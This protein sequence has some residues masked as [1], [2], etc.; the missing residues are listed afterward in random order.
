MNRTDA[1]VS[2]VIL[3]QNSVVYIEPVDDPFFAAH[4]D[5]NGIF[6]SRNA[7]YYF[8][9]TY[10]HILACAEQYQY[11]NPNSHDT[12]GQAHCTELSSSVAIQRQASTINLSPF[13]L[14]TA[15]L[16]DT[17][18]PLANIFGS[19]GGSGAA[20]LRASDIIFHQVSGPLPNNQWIIEVSAWF[21]T[22]LARIQHGVVEFATGPP[23]AFASD[24]VLVN[25]RTEIWGR[26][27]SSIK[28]GD[29]DDQQSFSALGV[30]LTLAIGGTVILV[31]WCL[32][33]FVE[34]LR[35]VLKK[36]MDRDE[37][38]KNDEIEL[39]QGGGGT[40][41]EVDETEAD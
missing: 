17:L 26:F 13:A 29:A 3:A 24:P 22:A 35:K 15:G 9:D 14:L 19:I 2:L 28:F 25:G 38:R 34:R 32:E 16:V 11:C 6:Q 18:L 31:S 39:L 41:L 10:F 7:T 37:Q 5:F 30:G 21:E 4:V 27:C 20:A 33:W 1:D 8:A 36:G 12:D 40:G 23:D